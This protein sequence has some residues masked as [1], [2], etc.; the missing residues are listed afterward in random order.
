MHE[1]LRPTCRDCQL[2]NMPAGACGLACEWRD[3]SGGG[4]G[5]PDVSAARALA[6]V[7][8]NQFLL[9][10]RA[11]ERA[12]VAHAAGRLLINSPVP[13][14]P[15]RQ[16]GGGGDGGGYAHSLRARAPQLYHSSR[17]SGANLISDRVVA[18]AAK[19]GR[20]LQVTRAAHAPLGAST[21]WPHRAG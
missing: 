18:V 9:R 16:A 10:L 14:Q 2:I 5:E 11:N 19:F 7:V 13:A 12:R 8:K 1:Y 15:C 6:G 20:R 21:I 17:R 4:G 3:Q